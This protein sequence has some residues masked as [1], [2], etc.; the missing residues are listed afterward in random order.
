[1]DALAQINPDWSLKITRKTDP[2]RHKHGKRQAKHPVS[3][4]SLRLQNT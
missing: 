1:M 3:E 2:M 4:P